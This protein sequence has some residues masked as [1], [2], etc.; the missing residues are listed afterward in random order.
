MTSTEDFSKDGYLAQL[1]T[2]PD[3]HLFK[4]LDKVPAVD[5]LINCESEQGVWNHICAEETVDDPVNHQLLPI[6]MDKGPI[7]KETLFSTLRVLVLNIVREI[8][9]LKL[10]KYIKALICFLVLPTHLKEKHFTAIKYSGFLLKPAS[11]TRK[12]YKD[13]IQLMKLDIEQ[14]IRTIS[15]SSAKPVE[16]NDSIKSVTSNEMKEAAGNSIKPESTREIVDQDDTGLAGCLINLDYDKGPNVPKKGKTVVLSDSESEASSQGLDSDG[17]VRPTEQWARNI[18]RRPSKR[19][20]SSTPAVG[21]SYNPTPNLSKTSVPNQIINLTAQDLV[22]VLDHKKTYFSKLSYRNTEYIRLRNKS[23][24]DGVPKN[25]NP[26]LQDILE[27]CRSKADLPGELKAAYEIS[28]LNYIFVL[29]SHRSMR[30]SVI[31]FS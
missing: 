19:V 7:N 4:K 27:Q 13:S 9:D 20:K 6:P 10:S 1:T 16:E 2:G 12:Y 25:I 28:V 29:I 23:P 14:T 31:G 11:S 15:S 21:T 17:E 5:T 3:A 26:D 24:R 30:N 18:D 8:K 22:K